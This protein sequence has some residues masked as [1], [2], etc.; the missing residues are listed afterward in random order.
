MAE[1]KTIIVNV[2]TGNSVKGVENLNKVVN[3]A[4][5]LKEALKEGESQNN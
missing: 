3:S 2:D 1:V 5:N 4:E